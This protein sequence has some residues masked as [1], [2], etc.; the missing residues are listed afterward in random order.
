MFV[1]IPRQV[2]MSDAVVVTAKSVSEGIETSMNTF[3]IGSFLF[4]FLVSISLKTIL[5]AIRV[6]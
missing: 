6:M 1:G 3:M 2:N 4:N 5:K